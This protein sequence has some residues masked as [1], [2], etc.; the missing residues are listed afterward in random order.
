ML[1][2][3]VEAEGSAGKALRARGI[4]TWSDLV[5]HLPHSHRDGRDERAVGKLTVGE[6]ATVAVTVRT[7]TVRPM[8]NCRRVEV[9][10]LVAGQRFGRPPSILVVL[11]S[12]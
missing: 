4:E 11:A 5:E 1:A 2:K 7:V 9:L 8:R 3:A 10:L 12:A 6:D